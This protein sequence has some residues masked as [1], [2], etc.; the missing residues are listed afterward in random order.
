MK[1]GDTRTDQAGLR[2]QGQGNKR[3][4]RRSGCKGGKELQMGGTVL[5]N[6]NKQYHNGLFQKRCR[7]FSAKKKTM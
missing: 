6:A 1:I 3:K 7:L 4:A 5:N 2:M